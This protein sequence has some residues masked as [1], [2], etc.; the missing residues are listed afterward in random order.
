[1]I[2]SKLFKKKRKVCGA[3]K[4]YFKST[5]DLRLLPEQVI[6]VEGAYNRRINK[7]IGKRYDTISSKLKSSELSAEFV[8]LPFIAQQ[9]Q[10]PRSFFS[11]LKYYFPF[12]TIDLEAGFKD[13]S[14]TFRTH[15][16]SRLFFSSLGY[17]D[18][19]INPGFFRYVGRDPDN[20]LVYEYFPFESS[21]KVAVLEQTDHYIHSLSEWNGA[22]NQLDIAEDEVS[23]LDLREET[24][25]P[26][27]ACKK[28]D[29][30]HSKNGENL[31]CRYQK[32]S[33]AISRSL[34]DDDVEQPDSCKP[35]LLFEEE[36]ALESQQAVTEHELISRIKSDIK[37]LKELGFYEL[38]IKEIGCVLFEKN[39]NQMFQPSR[40]YMT[41]DFRIYLPDFGNT[42]ITMASLPK[43]L[44]VFFLRHPEGISLKTLIDYKKE[45]LEIYK[46]LSYR[47]TYHNMVES[48]NRICNP[49]EGSI[50]EKLSRIKEAFLRTMSIDTAKYYIV[51]GERGMKKRIEIDRSLVRLPAAFEEIELTI[52]L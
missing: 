37:N 45:L 10:N 16:I 20:V 28:E 38:L 5:I 30:R 2:L 50:N 12:P 46:L 26:S 33:D 36:K 25:Y 41:D 29:T 6:Y 43:T 47:E 35:L 7:V 4:Q 18:V 34:F 14:A 21:N 44:F 52:A 27:E 1:M 40:L 8:Y 17:D 11:I 49:L 9:F 48:V 39:T 22:D 19:Q 23:F 51:A 15:V 3:S 42:E 31:F 32:T 13:V 24:K